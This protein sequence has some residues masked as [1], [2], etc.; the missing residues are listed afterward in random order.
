MPIHADTLSTASDIA[1]G[2]LIRRLCD[3]HLD[4]SFYARDFLQSNYPEWSGAIDG[5]TE[6]QAIALIE[7]AAKTLKLRLE[8]KDVRP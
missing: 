2:C 1:L 7:S 4:P 5:M 3:I 8:A 6:L